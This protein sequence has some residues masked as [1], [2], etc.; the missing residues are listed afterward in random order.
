MSKNAVLQYL[1]GQSWRGRNPGLDRIKNLLERMGNPQNELQFIHVAGTN[2]KGSTSSMIA[3]VLQSAGYKTGLFTSPYLHRFH[4]RIRINNECIDD[5]KLNDIGSRV[6]SLAGEMVE[7]PSEFEMIT[8]IAM[9]HFAKENCDVV[10]LEVG[11]GGRFDPTN[12][13]CKPLASVIT[14]IGLDHTKELG[15]TL[16]DIAYEKGGIIKENGRVILYRQKP[17]VERVI[18]DICKKKRAA[19]IKAGRSDVTLIHDALNGQ[20][21]DA[22]EICGLEIRLLGSH[23]L[24]NAATAIQTILQLKTQGWHIPIEAIRD[25]MKQA[26]WP[27]RFEVVCQDPIFI[28]D[29]GHNV[30]CA[31]T[32]AENLTHYF[33]KKKK[34]LLVGFIKDKD[35]VGMLKELNGVA[36][37]YVV[38]E[39]PHP[40]AMPA[41]EIQS[42]IENLKKEV[43][44]CQSICQGIQSSVEMTDCDSVACSFG[45]LYMTG[46]IRSCFGLNRF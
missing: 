43:I 21:F 24:G 20:I 14:N 22:F 13:I 25:G 11:M 4:E 29:G 16:E 42:M 12:V 1:T 2:G 9:E 46:M 36:D 31:Q 40:Y 41:K 7:H 28:I 6:I 34:I 23:Q 35:H 17:S 30:Q 15:S 10:V 3:S 44:V 39:P 45:S 26:I 33:P 37:R 38:V 8:A 32:L 5:A 18:E 27:G 19:L